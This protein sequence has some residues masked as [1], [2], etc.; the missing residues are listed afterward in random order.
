MPPPYQLMFVS[1][2]IK[3]EEVVRPLRTDVVIN[4]TL[5]RVARLA[6]GYRAPDL[7]VLFRFSHQ[8]VVS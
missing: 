4:G 6:D 7:Q 2:F 8:I 5:Y 1:F 3:K